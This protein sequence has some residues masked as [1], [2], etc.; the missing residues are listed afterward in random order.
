V[1]LVR[2]RAWWFNKAPLSVTLM[3]LL[4]D[5][6]PLGL[7]ELA[8]MSGVLLAVCAVGNFGYAV[9]ELFDLE[10]DARAG[11][12]NAAAGVSPVQAWMVIAISAL[13]AGTIAALVGGTVA[14]ALTIAELCLP[15]AY[16]VPPL[17]VKER[18]WLGVGADALAAHVYPAM[19]AL[20]AV[21]H[22]AGEAIPS[23]LVA[24]AFAWAAAAGIRGIL[25]HQLHTA[26]RD[27]S[28]G[29]VTVVHTFG[30]QPV[31]RLVVALLLPVEILGFVAVMALANVGPLAWLLVLV[32]FA[33]EA[34][35]TASGAFTVT[36]F[37]PQGQ[38]YLPF[39]EE[40]LYKAWGP[41]VFALDAAWT[42]PRYL[43]FVPLYA[44]AFRPH[45]RA[46]GHRLMATINAIAR[47]GA[48]RS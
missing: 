4:L 36:A 41:I 39:L 45:L 2:W 28:A 47:P 15:L 42:D 34:A 48:Q 40:S 1:I 33:Y 6:R 19:L 22:L 13:I 44:L 17:R 32:Y 11:R 5:G 29:L 14:A 37:R 20:L 31:E 26:D 8:A 3:L 23:P 21:H 24:S 30:R 25:S 43:V 9:N 7:P 27:H 10:E 46:E 16:S 35:R 18:M 38:P 12:A